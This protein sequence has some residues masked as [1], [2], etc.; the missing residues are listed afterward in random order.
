M[1]PLSSTKL[2]LLKLGSH[3]DVFD[4]TNFAIKDGI[5][6]FKIRNYWYEFEFDLTVFTYVDFRCNY[7][8]DCTS[9]KLLKVYLDK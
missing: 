3:E 8:I 9:L 1:S 5:I 7:L 2:V 4:C 6:K